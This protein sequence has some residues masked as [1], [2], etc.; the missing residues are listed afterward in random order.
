[1]HIFKRPQSIRRKLP[2]FITGLLVAVVTA[3]SWLAYSQLASALL[4]TAGQRV[5]AVS[6]RLATAFA[7]SDSRLRRDGTPL[8]RDAS[9][10]RVRRAQVDPRHVLPDVDRANDVWPRSG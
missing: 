4:A 1:M 7:E 10:K 6:Q 5:I 9:L 3:F 8:S 2:L